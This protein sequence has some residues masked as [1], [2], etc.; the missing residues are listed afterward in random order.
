MG[1]AHAGINHDDHVTEVVTVGVIGL[2]RHA[3]GRGHLA[4]LGHHRP[5]PLVRTVDVA[6]VILAVL[7]QSVDAINLKIGLIQAVGLVAEVLA[8]A[9]V[10]REH[11]LDNLLAGIVK[12]LVL[13]LHQDDGDAALAHCGNA[14]LGIAAAHTQPVLPA[15]EPVGLVLQRQITALSVDKGGLGRRA[16]SGLMGAHGCQARQR[17]GVVEVAVG[18]TGHGQAVAGE[19]GVVE[20]IAHGLHLQGGTVTLCNGMPARLGGHSHGHEA[21]TQQHGQ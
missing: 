5:Q 14:R 1:L 15:R 2:E 8:H 3:V 13:E 17:R 10:T 19:N 7:G 4:G 16:L 6:A 18:A 21:T 12:L 20:G 11:R 9:L